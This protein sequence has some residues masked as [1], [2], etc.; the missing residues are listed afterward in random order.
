MTVET[1]KVDLMAAFNFSYWIFEDTGHSMR[2]L[3]C[4]AAYEANEGRRRVFS[5]DM[6]GGPEAHSRRPRRKTK[7]KKH[8]FTY[9]WHQAEVPSDHEPH[10]AASSTSSFKDGSKMNKAC[11]QLPVAALVHGS[12]AARPAP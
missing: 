5:C 10:E 8:G 12:G 4:A 11:L 3:L 6:F 2:A 1:P 9:I 7:H